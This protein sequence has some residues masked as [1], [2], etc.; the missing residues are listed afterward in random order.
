MSRC[1]VLT[2]FSTLRRCVAPQGST[3]QLHAAQLSSVRGLSLY[4]GGHHRGG[5]SLQKD[6]D[7]G[8]GGGVGP[9]RAQGAERTREERVMAEEVWSR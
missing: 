4:N 8:R 5:G 2:L 7:E 3:V 1:T 9:V 6:S